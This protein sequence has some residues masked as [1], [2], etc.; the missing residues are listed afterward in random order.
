MSDRQPCPCGSARPYPA[1]CGRFIEDGD[2]AETAEQLMRSRYSA[3]AL[4]KV[5]WLRATWA[6]ETC[7]VDLE[8]EP[9]L[10]WIGLRIV[11]TEAG[12]PA[13]D[14]GFVTFIARYRIGGRAHRLHERSRFQRRDGRWVYVDGTSIPPSLRP[15][16][17][18]QRRGGAG[19]CDP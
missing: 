1:C 8:S 2:V 6:P 18:G 14:R 3:Y 11:S 16:A 15:R 10:Q 9:P 12:S 4:G 19:R 5:H 13:D 7:P 17:P